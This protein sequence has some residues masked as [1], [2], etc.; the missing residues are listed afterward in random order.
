MEPTTPFSNPNFDPTQNPNPNPIPNP[1]RTFVPPE[2][3]PPPHRGKFLPIL[4][5]IIFLIL[6]G[7]GVFAYTVVFEAPRA[8]ITKSWATITSARSVHQDVTIKATLESP[9]ALT[10]EGTIAT[11][12][13]RG[14]DTTSPKKVAMTV[15]GKSGGFSV[16]AELRFINDTLYGKVNEFPFLSLIAF[17][18]TDSPI[19]KWYSVSLSD[20]ERYAIEQGVPADSIAKAKEQL[21]KLNVSDPVFQIDTL[22]QTG[23]LV[24]AARASILKVDGVWARQYAVTINKDKLTE[25]IISKEKELS[26]PVPDSLKSVTFEPVLVT[27]GLFDYSLKKITGGIKVSGQGPLSFTVTY[28]NINGAIT[29]S[30]PDNAISLMDYIQKATE[31]AKSKAKSAE[32]KAELSRIRSSAEIYYDSKKSSYTNLC[33]KDS[34]TIASLKIVEEKSGQKPTCRANSKTFLVASD[35]LSNDL[36]VKVWCAD[37]TGFSG[38]L[39][40]IPTGYVCK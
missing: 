20:L 4:L 35:I 32:I 21:S 37:S 19:G 5:I 31:G 33:T 15:T 23:V 13:E 30:K 22:M 39:D 9:T 18:A 36:A 27:I 28:S 14:A 29:V 34:L 6:I 25:F 1:V 40:K 26:V 24:P 11:D 3:L 12:V 10:A 38:G 17:S 2:P 16:G 7:G 8:A